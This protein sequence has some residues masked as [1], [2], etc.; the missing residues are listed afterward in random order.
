M[1][2]EQF[3]AIIEAPARS[4]TC[5]S[6]WIDRRDTDPADTEELMADLTGDTPAPGGSACGRYG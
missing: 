1:T 4:V 3:A 6:W 2:A 5:A